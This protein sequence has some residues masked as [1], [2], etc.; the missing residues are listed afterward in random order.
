MTAV[1]YRQILI[2]IKT[3]LIGHPPAPSG[4]ALCRTFLILPLIVAGIT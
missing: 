4:I 1:L 3:Q 2:E